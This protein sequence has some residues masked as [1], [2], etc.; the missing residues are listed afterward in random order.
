MIENSR[1]L[2][3]VNKKYNV[4]MKAVGDVGLVDDIYLFF[5]SLFFLH[6]DPTKPCTV[7]HL[8]YFH[9]MQNNQHAYT[10]GL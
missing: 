2:K 1:A 6:W 10:E 3:I 9:F 5:F 7:V 4:N 8:E